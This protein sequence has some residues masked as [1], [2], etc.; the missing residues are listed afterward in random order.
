MA[1]ADVGIVIGFHSPDQCNDFIMA[2]KMMKPE[3]WDRMIAGHWKKS[4]MERYG[5]PDICTLVGKYDGIAW[6]YGNANEIQ[7]MLRFA[8][9]NFTAAWKL[10]RFGSDIDDIREDYGNSEDD[11]S[12]E[13]AD[14]IHDCLDVER[15]MH[16]KEDGKLI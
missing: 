5:D 9:N 12:L 6:P 13:I 1:Y 8:A 14:H 4:T 10:I 15:T 11:G 7:D 16:I 3:F 2:Y